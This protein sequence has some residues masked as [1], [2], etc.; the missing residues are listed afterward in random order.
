MAEQ[1]R[2]LS[3]LGVAGE[4]LITAGVLVLL[5]LGWQLWLNDL[6]LGTQLRGQAE[7]LS[8]EWQQD[9][10]PPAT[11]DPEPTDEP[12]AGP[13]PQDDPPVLAAP[14][15]TQ[16]LALL[17]VP[18]F[19]PDYYRPIRQGIGTKTVLNQGGLGHYP[20]TQMPGELGNFVIASHRKAYGGNLEHI[21][22]LQLGDHIYVESPEGWYSYV[23][24]NTEHVRPTGVGVLEPVPQQPGVAPEEQ[25]ITLQTCNPFFSSAE[26]M[27][28]Y[29]VFDGWYPRSGGPPSEIAGIVQAGGR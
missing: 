11:P 25:L 10:E 27:L 14:A 13:R 19:G 23:Y 24:R 20:T 6:I 28:A 5:F 26:R 15:E 2:R 21:H 3:V 16:V 4:L 7:E 18:R 17:I 22:E 29:G 1:T 12:D 8:Q 9:Y